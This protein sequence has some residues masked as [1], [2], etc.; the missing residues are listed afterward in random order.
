M[1]IR[2]TSIDMNNLEDIKRLNAGDWIR[3][4][5]PLITIRDSSMAKLMEYQHKN[6]KLP[7]QL[8]GKIVMYAAPAMS[9]RIIIGPTT[10]TRMDKG[11]GFLID[12]GV[13]AT[14]GKGKRSSL[15]DKL[16]KKNKTPYFVLMSGV[17][18]YLSEYFKKGKIIAFK[19]LGPEA[20]Y[21]FTASE[22][23][24]LTATDA[25]GRSIFN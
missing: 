13:I 22:L 17:S 23:L 16:I 9:K 15:A 24:L 4:T 11:L 20:V 6:K 19:E 1:K 12:H 7:F 5:G 3:Y 14:I 25:R 10:S 2:T 8:D 21:E 18:A